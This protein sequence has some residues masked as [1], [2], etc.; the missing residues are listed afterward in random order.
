MTLKRRRLL[1]ITVLSALTMMVG[2]YH[3]VPAATLVHPQGTALRAYLDTLSAF[4]LREVTVNNIDRVEGEFVLADAGGLILSATWLQAIT[5]SGFAGR[6]WTVRIPEANVT[7]VELKR[8]SWW[9]TGVVVGGLAVGTWLG[10]DALGVTGS[11]DGG[12]GGTG[13]P[14]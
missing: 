6:G 1:R 10:F 8:I 12:G 9:R 14:L 7:A 2:C 3:Y 5:G 4:E 11:R 13:P